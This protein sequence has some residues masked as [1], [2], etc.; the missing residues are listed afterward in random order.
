MA[1]FRLRIQD[2]KN[3][4]FRI[5]LLQKSGSV[6]GLE[7]YGFIE[8]NWHRLEFNPGEER[9]LLKLKANKFQLKTLQGKT[10]VSGEVSSLTKG[11]VLSLLVQ[12]KEKFYGLGDL[13]REKLERS[14]I[15]VRMSIEN[16]T[17]YIP[18]PFLMSSR[19]YGLFLNTTFVHTW[20]IGQNQPGKL[21][22]FIPEGPVDFFLFTGKDYKSILARYT[23]VTGRPCLAPKWSFG[24]WF[25]CRTQA[26]D[27]EVLSD[28]VK[29]RERKIPCDVI[30]LEPGWMET[31]YDY[32]TEKRWHPERFPF[33]SYAAC[34][35]HTFLAALKRLGYKV[36]LWLCNDYDLSYE[37]ERNLTARKEK[38]NSSPD[39]TEKDQHFTH[40]VYLDKITR[41]EQPW[42]EHLKKF[43]DQGVDFFKQDG[44]LQVCEHPDRLWA[45]GMKDNQMHNLYPLLYSQ[46]MYEG[47]KNY[48]GKRP[49]CFTPAGWAGLQRYTGTWT[50]DT[51]GGAKT[52]GGCLNLAMSGHGLLTCDM[53]VTTKEGIHYGFLLP[54]AQVNSWNYFRHPWLLG[55]Q[56]YQIFFDYACLRSQLVP[57]LYTCCFQAHKTG[58]PIIRPLPLEFPEIPELSNCLNAFFLGEQLLVSAFS[59]EIFLPP[60]RWLDFWTGHVYDGNQ[61][62]TYI[63]PPN[64]GGGL[65]LRE[66]SILPLGPICQYVD[67]KKEPFTCQVFLNS[68]GQADF[69]LYTD[70]GISYQYEKGNYRFL[71]F[72]ARLTGKECR[73]TYPEKEIKL[74]RIIL[75]LPD[76]PQLVLVN[77]NSFAFQWEEKLFTACLSLNV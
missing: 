23:A 2:G 43:I 8:K 21:K 27:F 33:P 28:A 11:Y 58:I 52:L 56:L 13:V 54:W 69:D 55:D 4:I 32:S 36:E 12:S 29:F 42:F 34:G 22:I 60:G 5:T 19:G 16:V 67:E 30:G 63:P 9:S 37:A 39:D 25:I 40:P 68:D 64:R 20:D 10:I 48:T 46:Q 62:I 31:Y 74:T 14:G 57:Y 59:P 35:P 7:R 73:I 77:G 1:G 65:F 17:Q 71:K 72:Q 49:C 26:N 47:F 38:E 45:N 6:S 75:N 50:G 70:D 44:A 15:K 18:I 3:G 24:L 66:N 53:E 76:K 61:K 51:G 41:P